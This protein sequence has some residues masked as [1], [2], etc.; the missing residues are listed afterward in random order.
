MDSLLMERL[1]VL[2]NLFPG[3]SSTEISC[4]KDTQASMKTLWVEG[5]RETSIGVMLE[6]SALEN[7][8]LDST[9]QFIDLATTV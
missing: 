5:I 8:Q 6:K 7:A 1:S 4:L 9:A 2:D 3:S